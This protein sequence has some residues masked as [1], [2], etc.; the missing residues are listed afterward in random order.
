MLRMLDRICDLDMLRRGLVRVGL[1]PLYLIGET[2]GLPETESEALEDLRSELQLVSW[3]L[4]VGSGGEK[5]TSFGSLLTLRVM[6]TGLEVLG[7]G[8]SATD[9]S[10]LGGDDDSVGSGRVAGGGGVN[11][12]AGICAACR[13]GDDPG[14]QISIDFEG[15]SIVAKV[16]VVVL[17]RVPG[18][19]GGP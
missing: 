15:P 1:R 8:V 5:T 3:K 14:R 17:R 9:G 4:L 18:G 2:V 7:G 13:W 11:L 19:C 12:V 10:G 16:D 6:G